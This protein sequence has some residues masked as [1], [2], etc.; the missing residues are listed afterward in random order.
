MYKIIDIFTQISLALLFNFCLEFQDGLTIHGLK[1][2]IHISFDLD[3][4]K[5]ITM[6]H[7]TL[8]C[9]LFLLMWGL[10]LHRNY[11]ICPAN[12]ME[13]VIFQIDRWLR[14][15]PQLRE[16]FMLIYTLVFSK[17]TLKISEYYPQ[18]RIRFRK[19]KAGAEKVKE[20]NLMNM[21]VWIESILSLRAWEEVLL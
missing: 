4:A 21:Y 19:A 10:K 8:L 17:D 7:W 16:Y 6:S 18:A 12:Q 9:Y 2:L 1:S 14:M 3:I 20:M 13:A 11:G 15:Q 5:T